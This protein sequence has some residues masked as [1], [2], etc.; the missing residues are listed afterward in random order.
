M[1]EAKTLKLFDSLS[2]AENDREENR[3][4]LMLTKEAREWINSLPSDPTLHFV[5]VM[6]RP[7]IGKSTLINKLFEKS[8]LG[9]EYSDQA[10]EL[11]TIGISVNKEPVEERTYKLV[12]LDSQGVSGQGRDEMRGSKDKSKKRND[13]DDALLTLLQLHSSSVVLYYYSGALSTAEQEN[14]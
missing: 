6:G 8:D 7:K 12:V 3:R 11:G 1:K 10:D 5:S 14:L 9:F 4:A 2:V 13:A